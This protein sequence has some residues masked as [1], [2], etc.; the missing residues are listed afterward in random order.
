MSM[1]TSYRSYTRLLVRYLRPQIRTVLLLGVA[2]LS[3]IGLQLIGPQILRSFVDNLQSGQSLAYATRLGFLFIGVAICQQVVALASVYLSELVGWAATN[4]LR[5]DLVRHCLGLDMSFHTSRTPGEMIERVDGDVNALSNFFSQFTIQVFSNILLLVGI[6]I[7][8]FTIDWRAGLVVSLITVIIA[9]ILMRLMNIATPY[10]EIERQ[11]SAEL[12]GFVEERLNGTE[13]LRA[14]GAREYVLRRFYEFSRK[15]MRANLKA[16]MMINV[17]INSSMV[18]YAVAIASGMAVSAYLYMNGQITLGS[19]VMVTFL[20]NLIVNPIERILNQLQEFQRAGASINR[21]HELLGIETKIPEQIVAIDNAPVLAEGPLRVEFERVQFSY[22]ENG[23][24]VIQD[25]TF[26]LAPGEVLG[27]LGRTGSGKTTLARLLFHLYNPGGGAIRIGGVD[28][29]DLP[30]SVLRRRVGMVSQNI[31]LFHASLRDNLTFFDPSVPEERIREVLEW[32]GLGAWMNSLPKGVDTIL[33]S[34][35][36]GL[37]AGEAQ[38]LAFARVF[39]KKPGLVILDE[40]TARL[41]PATEAL[42]ERAVDRLVEQS[43]AII[44]AHRLGTVERAGQ[45]MILED[46]KIL[47]NGKRAELAVDPESRFH[48]L[49]EAGLEEVL[50]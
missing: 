16:A 25:L 49:L 48:Q 13:E 22:E 24:A 50:A 14:N 37:S 35:G 26:K 17:L 30:T 38:L 3:G 40:A 39:L 15:L 4:A 46:G 28:L 29:R 32:L 45:I 44:I 23:Q 18:L 21:V 47:E 42:I 10:W 11:V 7:L 6:Q 31:Q 2:L 12:F 20:A 9:L 5:A 36:G 34:G 8:L 1:K 41:D 43:T 19:A 33:E 27:L